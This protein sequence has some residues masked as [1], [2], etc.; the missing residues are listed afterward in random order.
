MLFRMGSGLHHIDHCRRRVPGEAP[1]FVA[2]LM[3]LNVRIPANVPSGPLS[4]QVSIGG[5]ISQR[6]ITVTVQ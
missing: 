6:G 3:Q 2:G 4:I 5:N 1:G